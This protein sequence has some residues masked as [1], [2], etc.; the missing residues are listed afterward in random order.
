MHAIGGSRLI[1]Y[2]LPA[3]FNFP[4]AA[5]SLGSFWRRWHISL[6]SW[7]RD[8]LYIPLGGNRLGVPKQMRNLVITML[9]GGIWHGA[10]W[11]FII[12]GA[13]HGTVLAIERFSQIYRGKI[14]ILT[15]ENRSITS[16]ALGWL[17]TQ[18]IVLLLWIPFR[19]KTLADSLAVISGIFTWRTMMAG[20]PVAIPITLLVLPIFCDTVFI[21][22]LRSQPGRPLRLPELCFGLLLL[23]ALAFGLVTNTGLRI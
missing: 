11:N 16:L 22:L 14:L 4:Y 13:A 5:A 8:Y 7:L 10:S 12:W 1:G 2:K 6:S 19:A 23:R 9:L 17:V 15:E 18:T 20:A 3:N 21:R